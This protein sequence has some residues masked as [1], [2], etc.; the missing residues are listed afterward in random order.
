LLMS[1]LR[2]MSM[3]LQ[4]FGLLVDSQT[5]DRMHNGIPQEAFLMYSKAIFGKYVINGSH[6][7]VIH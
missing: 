1:L 7:T 6:M 2:P 4:D 3:P 5:F